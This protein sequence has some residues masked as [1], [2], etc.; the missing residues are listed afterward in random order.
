MRN[1]EKILVVDDNAINLAIIEELLDDDYLVEMAENGHEA[2]EIAS[3]FHPDLILLDIMM[4]GIDG[5]ETCRR[6]RADPVMGKAKI[7]M[8]SA[9]AMLADRLEG[10]EAGADDYL[11]KPFDEAEFLAKIK[12]YLNLKSIE[13]VDQLKD[14]ILTLISHETFTPL[15]GILMS[16]EMLQK[17]TCSDDEAHELI[18]I[19][20]ESAEI[21]NTFMRKIMTFSSLKSGTYNLELQEG[22]LVSIINTICK[23]LNDQI[24][25]K[26]ITINK[27]IQANPPL[28]LDLKQIET[29]VA[30]VLDNAIQFSSE[31][32][33]IDISILL[34]G[35][36]I[37]LT[38]QDHGIGIT[39]EKLPFVFEP[40]HEMD[41]HHHSK[42]HGLGL[43][44]SKLIIEKHQ[45]SI[46][47][48]SEP[49]DGTRVTIQLPV[50]I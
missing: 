47:I 36:N 31:G 37:V 8:V 49:G 6:L 9:K 27:N 12:V 43:A 5:Y 1:K 33:Q 25:N 29:V 19:I 3:Q 18:H 10:Y 45:G 23:K 35:K 16:T 20:H 30:N 40:F 11:I 13:E 26:H 2:L 15:N 41:I 7:I 34:E 32:A 24:T 22:S 50:Q 21:L 14:D 42:G 4:P 44:M 38:I 46:Q 39:P 48:E 17:G 28:I